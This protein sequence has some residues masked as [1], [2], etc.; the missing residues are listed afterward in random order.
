MDIAGARGRAARI[1]SA[2]RRTRTGPAMRELT[3]ALSA[4]LRARPCRPSGVRDVCRALCEE[5]SARRGGR[6]VEV[7][8]E[9]FP[10][11]IE[12]TG[13]WVE[14]Q[15]FDLVIVEERAEDV[16]QLVILGHELWHLH[17]GHRHH[18][19]GVG[20]VAAGVLAD[21]SGWD[22][23]AL[24]VAARNGSREDDEAEADDF[25]HRLAARFRR[26]L[27]DSGPTGPGAAAGAG[28]ETSAVQRTLGY[29]G[30]RGT[31]R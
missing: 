3:G 28:A 14:F 30:R 20:T 23:I 4:A 1:A 5:M 25:G 8:F 7:R 11:E 22:S 13:L 26:Y 31:A 21:R 9:R 15:E 16:Q 12:V 2:L 6:P 27:S 18:H 17:A 29:R 19:H 10:D 24:T